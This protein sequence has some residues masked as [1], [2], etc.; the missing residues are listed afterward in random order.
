[1]AKPF[2]VLVGR[3]NVGKSTLFNRL[4][5]E[6]L[7]VVDDQP[8]TTRDRVHAPCSWRDAEFTLVDTGGIEPLEPLRTRQALAAGSSDFVHEVREQAEIAIDEADVVVFLVDGQ[9]GLTAADEAV[10]DILRKRIGQRQKEGRPVPP[11]LVAANKCEADAPRDASVEFYKL[12]LGDVYPVSALHGVGT[13][14]L[15]DAVV[16]HLP[17]ALPDQADDSIRIAIVGRPNV[18][19]SSLFNRLIGEPRVIVSEVPGTTRDAIDTL[20][21]FQEAAEADAEAE[22]E[23]DAAQPDRAPVPIT[24]IDTAGIRKRGTIEPGVEK[25]SVLRAFKAVERADVALLLIDAADGITAQDEHIGGYVIDEN[26]SVLVVVNKWDRVESAEK[27]ARA[28]R[29]VPGMGLLT[30]KMEAFLAVARER[31]N[32]IAYAPTLFVS[33]KTGFRCDQLLPAALRVNEARSLRIPTSDVNR[34]LREAA[35]KHAPPTK[36]GR[37][38]KFYYGA[39]VGTNPPTFVI[40]INDTELAHFTYRRFIENRIR[41]E[42][43]FLGTP[44]RLVF[45]GRRQD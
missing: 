20:I 44:I 19:K 34:I 30:E 35:E 40:H 1:V 13:G 39:Q 26:K 8:G 37:R 27:V 25:Y 17:P 22:A 21:Q 31:F 29:P 15:L 9:V 36:G 12:G 43:N 7:S 2:V 33:A 11:V 6:R 16:A 45:K 18:G 28:A 14:D 4:A 24:L 32:F 42:F 5:G 23:A 3:P 41:D 38:L 10:G